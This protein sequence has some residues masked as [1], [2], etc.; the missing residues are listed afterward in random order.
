MTGM[1]AVAIRDSDGG[2][3][4]TGLKCATVAPVA[5]QASSPSAT[6]AVYLA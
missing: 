1:S 2:P 4:H 5:V 3:R 6:T